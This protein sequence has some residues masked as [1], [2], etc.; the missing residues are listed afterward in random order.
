MLVV[1]ALGGNAL[2]RRGEP[3]E[4]SIQRKN[5]RVAAA[6]IAAIAHEHRVVIT[7]GNGPQ[8][9]LLAMQSAAFRD[10]APY[11][12]DVLGAES[13]G[14][15][16]YLLEEALTAELPDRDTAM[17]L[18]LVEVS[19]DDHAFADPTKPIGPV[20]SKQES[21]TLA[22]RTGWHFIPDGKGFRRAIASPKPQ[23]IRGLGAIR[24]LVDAGVVLICGG[25]GGVPVV[26]E[27]GRLR[28]VEAVI[29]K[30]FTSAMLAEAIGA[31]ALLL[32]TDV[33]G[34]FTDWP[35]AKAPPLRYTTP[36]VLRRYNFAPG[37]M[38]PKVE[39]ACRFVERTHRRAM[40]GAVEDLQ[41][42][43]EETSGTIIRTGGGAEPALSA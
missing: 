31:D 40:I 2:L 7:H 37:S 42:L 29:D 4:E 23:R 15:I 1:V 8:V 21:R 41:S 3:P 38:A 28:G 36:A 18:T 27:N 12:L 6:A 34:V 14:M 20:Y 35:L 19:L 22:E 17:L 9:G 10:V 11:S 43:L 26:V 16:G 5:V 13:A 25:G 24:S 32:L 33:P 39:A 30:D